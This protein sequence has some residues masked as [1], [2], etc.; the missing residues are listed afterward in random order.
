VVRSAVAKRTVFFLKCYGHRKT[1]CLYE[2]FL[3]GH[4]LTLHAKN[5]NWTNFFVPFFGIDSLVGGVN[6]ATEQESH[7]DLLHIFIAIRIV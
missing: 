5:F 1:D 3:C 7:F 4:C 2:E 6:I